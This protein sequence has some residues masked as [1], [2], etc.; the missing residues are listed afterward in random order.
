MVPVTVMDGE[1]AAY[2][3]VLGDERGGGYARVNNPRG[4]RTLSSSCRSRR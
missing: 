3:M 2:Y 1:S 4:K